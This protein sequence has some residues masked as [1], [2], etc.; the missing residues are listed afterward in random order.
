M[1]LKLNFGD[2]EDKDMEEQEEEPSDFLGLIKQLVQN[3][4]V[5]VGTIAEVSNI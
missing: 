5:N 2:G 3:T 4:F 1:K